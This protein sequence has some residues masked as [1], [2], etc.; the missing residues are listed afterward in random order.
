MAGTRLCLIQNRDCGWEFQYSAPISCDT[1]FA[2]FCEAFDSGRPLGAH[3]EG[4]RSAL[5]FLL[6]LRGATDAFPYLVENAENPHREKVRATL[7][8]F[9]AFKL[10]TPEYF[11][12]NGGFCHQ[13]GSLSSDTIA[14]GCLATLDGTDFKL[15]HSWVKERFL[16]ARV[17]LLK[18]TLEV[19]QRVSVRLEDRF[20]AVMK[21]LH[22]VMACIPQFEIHVAYRFFA[23]NAGA[24]FFDGIQQNAR[25]LDQKLKSMA[26]DLA[27]WRTLFDLLL[28]HSTNGHFS[29]F[30]IPHFLSFDKPFVSLTEGLRLDGL[31]YAEG[32]RRCEQILNRP[33][34]EAVSDLLEGVCREF[35]G[36]PAREDRS[37]RVLNGQESVEQ[38]L[39]VEAELTA[40]LQRTRGLDC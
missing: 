19:F 13:S 16:W 39:S 18:C 25:A 40:E 5:A 1:N 9:A 20:Y 29:A 24:S 12:A 31:I 32:R 10:T 21:F 2:S 8:A 27:H 37:R 3:E 23:L 7:R 14:D 26:W 33:L 30:P 22:E 4:F 38:L 6:P 34:I 11:A 15:I 28:V 35:Y 17:V 36:I